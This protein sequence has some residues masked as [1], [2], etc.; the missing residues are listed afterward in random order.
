MMVYEWIQSID[1]AYPWALVLLLL[2]PAM[3]WWRHRMRRRR[4]ALTVTTVQ[5]FR[6]PAGRAAFL[7]LLP[8]LRTLALAALIIALARPQ[9]HESEERRKGAG[10]DIMLCIDVSG[11]MKARDFYPTRLDVA[12]E[13]A[14]AFVQARPVDRIGLVVF[15]GESYTL[16]PLSSDHGLV[17]EQIRGLRS[18][19]LQPGTLIGE[20]LATSVE[21]LARGSSASRVVV[22]LTDGRE[23]A[24]ETRLID[25]VTAISIARARNVRV[26]TIGMSILGG[27]GVSEFGGTPASIDEPLL[28]RMAKET[29]GQ[30]FRATDRQSLLEIYSEIDRLE[31]SPFDIVRRERTEEF[32]AYFLAAGLL[33]LLVELLLSNT[34]LRTFPQ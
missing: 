20:G 28:R 21:R 16:A 13:V 34:V 12:R 29:G 23:E 15:E 27:R 19:L 26:Y 33:L 10:I 6:G 32:Y 9:R 4:P 22:L 5:A 11:S 17:L 24:P 31:K 14:E 30:Y 25:P 2:L 3:A 8:L 7:F 1:F 18:G